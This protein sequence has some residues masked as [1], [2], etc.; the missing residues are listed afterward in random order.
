MR[1]PENSTRQTGLS[2]RSHFSN[3]RNWNA[4][5]ARRSRSRSLLEYPDSA[6]VHGETKPF[7]E[8]MNIVEHGGERNQETD[9]A[10]VRNA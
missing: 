7:C 8:A 6:W 4:V 2:L 9:R 5:P 1:F 3:L 10:E